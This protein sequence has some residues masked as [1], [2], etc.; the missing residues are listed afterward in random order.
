MNTISHFGALDALARLQPAVAAP[1]SSASGAAASR[2]WFDAGHASD[3]LVGE[4]EAGAHGLGVCQHAE[5]ILGLLMNDDP[6]GALR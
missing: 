6:H 1:A 2:Q 4:V 5:R 3:T